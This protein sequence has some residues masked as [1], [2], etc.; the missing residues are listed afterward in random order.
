MNRCYWPCPAAVRS[1]PILPAIPR[2][3]STTKRCE[4]VLDINL[5]LIMFPKRILPY[6]AFPFALSAHST[7]RHPSCLGKET[8]S[9]KFNEYPSSVWVYGILRRAMSD[10]MTHRLQSLHQAWIH[11]NTIPYNTYCI[12][13]KLVKHWLRS[14]FWTSKQALLNRL[15]SRL[16]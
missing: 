13:S 16:N 12:A 3:E 2:T 1:P 7:W 4:T 10:C 9:V 6:P 5:I 15:A 14:P 11:Y 8:V